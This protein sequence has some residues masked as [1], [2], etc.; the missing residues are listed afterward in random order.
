MPGWGQRKIASIG[1]GIRRWTTLHGLALNVNPD[2]GFF[3]HIVP[4]GIEGCADDLD[5]AGKAARALPT[6]DV[7]AIVDQQF[8]AVFG[9]QSRKPVNARKL[10][11]NSP[12]LEYT[13]DALSC[14]PSPL[15]LRLTRG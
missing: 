15:N 8:A 4:C 6:A 13:S 10:H 11:S 9:Y 7:G 2:L 12:A 14:A 3:D 5:G 1:V